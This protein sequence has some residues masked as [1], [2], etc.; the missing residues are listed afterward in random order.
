MEIRQLNKKK[1]LLTY[2]KN[3]KLE[4]GMATKFFLTFKKNIKNV[5]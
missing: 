5:C 3:L 4:I 2:M 1:Q